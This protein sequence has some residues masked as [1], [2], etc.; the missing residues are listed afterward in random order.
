MNKNIEKAL[1]KAKDVNAEK[2]AEMQRVSDALAEVK[3]AMATAERLMNNATVTGDFEAYSKSKKDKELASDREQMLRARYE[4]L[5]KE[6]GITFEDG[7]NFLK[8]VRAEQQ[9]VYDECAKKLQPIIEQ[10]LQI[11]EETVETIDSGNEALKSWHY[12]C[13]KFTKKDEPTSKLES[14]S[15]YERRLFKMDSVY[16][17]LNKLYSVPFFE[18]VGIKEPKKDK[19]EVKLW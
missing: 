7:Q 10:A 13:R 2:K 3:S 18:Y 5:S 15:Y 1:Q 16:G 17:C 6:S 9:K 11:L 14:D 12:G 8:E 19:R 4:I